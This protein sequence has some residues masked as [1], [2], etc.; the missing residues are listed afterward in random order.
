MYCDPNEAV[1]AVR[2]LGQM[3]FKGDDC[4]AGGPTRRSSM[5]MLES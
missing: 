3:K 2:N 5:H 4:G 1:A